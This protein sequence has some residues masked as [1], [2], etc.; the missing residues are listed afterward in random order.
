MIKNFLLLFVFLFVLF[1]QSG[2]STDKRADQFNNL[3]NNYDEFLSINENLKLIYDSDF[4]EVESIIEK[5]QNTFSHIIQGNKFK[6]YQSLVKQS[7]GFY[8]TKI[9]QEINLLLFINS[10]S[11]VT[12]DKPALR[13]PLPI[14]QGAKWTWKGEENIDDEKD[15]ITLKGFCYGVEK[16][17]TKAGKFNCLKTKLEVIRKDGEKTTV[18]EWRA[19]NLGIVK[20]EIEMGNHGL[21]GII[22]SIF[23]YD[24]ISFELKNIQN[25]QT[26]N[27]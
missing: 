12:Y 13:L 1:F 3:I 11:K 4:G 25:N 19:A 27:D 7:D 21:T 20:T 24:K 2:V 15:E 26:K 16:V 10:S 18:V 14:Y 17:E 9:E 22:K 6:Y 8:I 23:G 5:N